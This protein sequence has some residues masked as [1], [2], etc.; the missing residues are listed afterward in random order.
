[1]PETGRRSDILAK[2]AQLFAERGVAATTVRE[3]AD[4]VGMLSGSLYHHFPSKDAIVEGVVRGYLDDLLAGYR[5]T[6]AAALAPREAVRRLI[7]VSVEAAVAHPYASEVYQNEVGYLRAQPGLSNV[8]DAGAEV[9]Q[10]WHDVL[11][12]GV[13]A[14]EF[15]DDIPVR[16]IYRVLRDAVFLSARWHRRE[17]GYTAEQL[18]DDLAGLFL[19]GL[20]RAGAA[21]RPR[22]RAARA[23]A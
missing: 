13:A 4:A 21:K 22:G 9:Q 20:G 5:E 16:I 1:M 12:A 17:R 19:D 14:G 18:S 8:T 23:G 7:L 11:T 10:I 6:V 2:A 15:R 3:I